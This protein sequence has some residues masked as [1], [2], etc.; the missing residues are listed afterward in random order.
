MKK[1]DIRETHDLPNFGSARAALSIIILT[2]I[3]AVVITV[4][5]HNVLD[6]DALRDLV[7]VTVFAQ[8]IAVCSI[9]A[10]KIIAVPV[11][12][13][14]AKT[15]MAVTFAVLLLVTALATEV[16]LAVVFHFNLVEHPWPAWNALTSAPWP[17]WHLSLL[18]RNLLISMVVI[19]LVL[20]YLTLHHRARLETQSK[21]AAT[22]QALQSRIRPH[23]LFNSMN[24]IAGL[25]KSDPEKAEHALHD[26]A[27]VFRVLLAD[28]RK[29]V[30]ITAERDLAKQY[31]DIEKLRLGDRLH[32]KWL[33]SNVPRS[34]QIPSLTL[35]PL[36]ENAIYHGI[37]PLFAGGQ[38]K[39][40][41]WGEQDMLNIMITN[42]VPDVATQSHRKGNKIAMDNIRQR[43]AQYFGDQATLQTFEQF[44]KYHV[45]V[46][47]PIIR[48]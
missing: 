45:K 15:G 23:F 28:A 43:L 35:Q 14:A 39:V 5:R 8:F 41:L 31:L 17:A 3:I 9:I 42:P 11:R 2:Q 30:P 26:L 27:D 36:L 46:R 38:I 22:L 40:E 25:L 7:I 44:G 1:T 16:A 18:G 34:A 4:D 13:M 12:H 32:V 21:Q 24:S 48:G 29:L 33:A 6:G 47:M 20:R 37:E 10:L 19:P